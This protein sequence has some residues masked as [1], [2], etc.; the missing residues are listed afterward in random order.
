[1]VNQPSSETN[2]DAKVGATIKNTKLNSTNPFKTQVL[3]D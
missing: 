3:S 1:M 2:I